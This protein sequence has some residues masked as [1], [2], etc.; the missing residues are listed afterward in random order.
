MGDEARNVAR[1]AL[2]EFKKWNKVDEDGCPPTV[3][4]T[5]ESPDGLE[6]TEVAFMRG[7]LFGILFDALEEI[8]KE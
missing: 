4:Q 7:D 3:Y 6:E 8:A 1:K 5:F 2:A